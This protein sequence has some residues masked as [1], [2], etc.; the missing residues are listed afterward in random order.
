MTGES[1]PILHGLRSA[2]TNSRQWPQKGGIT[3][4]ET[5]G[6]KASERRIYTADEA[7]SIAS[8]IVPG[9][10]KS[11][12]PID[13]RVVAEFDGEMD[14]SACI[15]RADA[16]LYLGKNSGKNQV[17]SLMDVLNLDRDR[18]CDDGCAQDQ[19]GAATLVSAEAA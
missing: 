14:P 1:P 11:A 17:V 4:M 10:Y 8:G 3:H 9:P 15:K 12:W 16:A 13:S 5:D 2:A 7:D 18:S 6:S 19:D